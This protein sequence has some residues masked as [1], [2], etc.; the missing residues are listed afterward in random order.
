M[1]IQAFQ[2]GGGGGGWSLTKPK[3]RQKILQ[4]NFLLNRKLKDIVTPKGQLKI[5]FIVT[6]DYRK[7]KTREKLNKTETFLQK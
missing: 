4:Y 1:L 2:G 7:Q 3:S 5:S 6:R